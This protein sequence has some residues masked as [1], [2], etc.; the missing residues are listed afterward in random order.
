MSALNVDAFNWVISIPLPPKRKIVLAAIA[1]HSDEDWRLSAPI[2]LIAELCCVSP[3]TVSNALSQLRDIGLISSK[4]VFDE[5]G[6]QMP[7]EFTLIKG[8]ESTWINSKIEELELC[9]GPIVGRAKKGGRPV[10]ASVSAMVLRRDGH[11]CVACSS[12]ENLT[13]DHIIPVSKGGTS[14]YGNL[15]TLCSTCNSSKGTKDNDEWMA[16]RRAAS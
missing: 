13:M 8:R 14:A 16:S 2:K 11:A 6:K 1:A 3:R 12:A 5:T 10:S 15:Q 9:G 4:E 7:N